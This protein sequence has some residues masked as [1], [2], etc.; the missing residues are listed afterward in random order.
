MKTPTAVLRII[1]TQ[2][3]EIRQIRNSYHNGKTDP[4]TYKRE[5]AKAM[6]RLKWMREVYRYIE[7]KPKEAYLRQQL[8]DLN[9]VRDALKIGFNDWKVGRHS[10]AS[11]QSQR[12]T[13]RKETGLDNIERQIKTVRFVLGE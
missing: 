10:G 3:E 12:A 8:E 4:K 5:E 11:D 13:Y 1:G 2:E 7:T 6:D 9:R